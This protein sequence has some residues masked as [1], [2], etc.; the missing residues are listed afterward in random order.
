MLTVAV[1]LDVVAAQ[2]RRASHSNG[3]IPRRAPT[4]CSRIRRDRLKGFSICRRS[5]AWDCGWTRLNWPSGA[6]RS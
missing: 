2:L 4:R 6:W 1:Q 5:Q 3:T